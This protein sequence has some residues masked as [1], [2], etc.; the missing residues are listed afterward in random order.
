M[1]ALTLAAMAWI[2]DRL[3]GPRVVWRLKKSGHSLHGKRQHLECDDDDTAEKVLAVVEAHKGS[4]TRAEVEELV[5]GPAEAQ[6]STAPTFGDWSAECLTDKT[7][8]SPRTLRDYREILAYRILPAADEIEPP[9]RHVAGWRERTMDS[10]LPRDISRYLKGLQDDGLAPGTR[11]KHFSLIFSIFAAAVKNKIIDENPC[12]GTDFVRN[13]VDH[14]DQ[15][16]GDHV[17]LTPEEWEIFHRHIPDP[18]K[19]FVETLVATAGRIGEV[20]ALQPRDIIHPT[21]RDPFPRLQIRRAWKKNEDGE[22]YLGTTKGRQRRSN[23]IDDDLYEMLL[24]LAEGKALD[25][26]LFTAPEGGRLEYQNFLNRVWNRA[27]VAAMRCPAHL[28]PPQASPLAE[29]VGVCGDYGGVSGKSGKPCQK[30]L[31]VGLDRCTWHAG[32]AADAVSDCDCPTVLHRRPSIHD[33]RHTCAAWMLAD[34]TVAP[35]YVSRYLGHASMEVT[36]KVY[37][38]LVP[39]GEGAAVIAIARARGRKTAE[40]EK[41]AERRKKPLRLKPAESAAVGTMRKGRRKAA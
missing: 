39:S 33:L 15:G 2:E 22:F 9:E 32:P 31:A 17:Y 11:T 38:G 29:R 19:D 8:I 35:L 41:P 3:S 16:D 40:P 23:R 26:L 14:D 6:A 7:S 27:A 34:P 12:E 1:G 18:Y 20:T 21:A 5:L 13:Q 37:A 4:L 28:P 36:D 24:R 30:E 10:F 25:G